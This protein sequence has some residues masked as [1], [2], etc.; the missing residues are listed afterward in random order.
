[1]NVLCICYEYPPIGGGGGPVCQGICEAIVAAGHHVDV[2]T[3]AMSDLPRREVRGGVTIHRHACR[4]RH[5]HFTTT[6]ELLTGLRPAY[7][8]A[9]QLTRQIQYDLI[10]CHFVV[11]SG[12]VT[13][14]LARRTGLPYLITAHGS[15]IPGYNRDRFGLTHRLIAPVSRRILRHAAAVTTPSQ[16]LRHLLQKLT[17]VPVAVIPNGFTPPPAPSVPRRRRVLVVT[18]MFERKGVQFVVEAMRGMDPAW[19]LCIVGDGPYLPAIKAR[20]AQLH[21]D[22]QFFGYVQ[23]QALIDLYH[24]AEIFA[25]PS[26]TENF[27]VVLLEAMAA[28]CAVV[29]TAGTGC[30]EVVGPTAVCVPPENPAALRA[31]FE[32]LIADPGQL[33][34][35]QAMGR[36]RVERFSWPKIGAEFEQLYRQHARS[37]RSSPTATE[38]AT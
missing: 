2:V 29:T 8:T 10:H 35:L 18:R 20:A 5:R 4:R 9:L 13:S 19:E 32:R 37:G 7:R 3:S 25:L 31:A 24:S 23:G 15:D 38:A 12:L 11:P 36:Q 26:S 27:P 30:E 28:G 1:M 21:V 34:Q 33:K 22:A 17:P 6:D 16:F 14:W